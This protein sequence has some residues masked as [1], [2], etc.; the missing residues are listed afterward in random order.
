[1]KKETQKNEKQ[2]EKEGTKGVFAS[3]FLFK[4]NLVQR[5]KT[6]KEDQL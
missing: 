4:W 1:M 3:L 5:L 6:G 2:S